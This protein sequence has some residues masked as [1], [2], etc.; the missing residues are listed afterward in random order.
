MSLDMQGFVD[1]VFVSLPA[2]RYALS[3]GGYVNGLWVDGTSTTTSHT[4][5]IQP[6]SEREIQNLSAG[7][8]RIGDSRK[9]YINDGTTASV[10]QA[11]EW[12]FDGQRWKCIKL[13]NRPWRNYCKVI[14]SRFDEQ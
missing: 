11:D 5:N 4:V 7:G 9:L 13:D 3:G 6:L 12:E 10:S 1:D 14:V 8:E 2:T